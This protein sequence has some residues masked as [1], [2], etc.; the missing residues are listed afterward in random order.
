MHIFCI[1]R[2]VGFLLKHT[3]MRILEHSRIL[4]V[5]GHRQPFGKNSFLANFFKVYSV[6]LY[7]YFLCPEVRWMLKNTSMRILEDSRI[8]RFFGHLPCPFGKILVLA[9]FFKL[10]SVGLNACFFVSWGLLDT[11]KYLYANFGRLKNFEIFLPLWAFGKILFFC[12]F[13]Q[14][15]FCWSKCIFLVS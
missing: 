2:S 10:Y 5:F 13:C 1:V 3:S 14:S 4:I 15:I 8:L 11:K 6:G 9:N 7:G 12:K